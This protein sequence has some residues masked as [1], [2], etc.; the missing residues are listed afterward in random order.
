[1]MSEDEK[2]KRLSVQLERTA[3]ADT[4]KVPC[5][6]CGTWTALPLLYRCYQCGVW[7]CSP[8][9]AEHWPEAAEKREQG[10]IAAD[11]VITARLQ[12]KGRPIHSSIP[13]IFG[14]ET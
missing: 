2:N 14:G 8:C 1:M 3:R 10:A 7:L 11:A 9:G 12:A 13:S 5:A 6:C 4:I